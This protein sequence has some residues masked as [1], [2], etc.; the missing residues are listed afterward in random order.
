MEMPRARL[1]VKFQWCLITRESTI[2]PNEF[3][4]QIGS[5]KPCT[6]VQGFSFAKKI[7]L[8]IHKSY[9][10]TK[11][12]ESDGLVGLSHNQKWHN[13]Q[14]QNS[15]TLFVRNKTGGFLK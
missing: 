4:I 5:I 7:N 10:P 15:P 12:K 13:L 1:A 14:N 6:Y 9:A 11:K 3:K 2:S 8:S